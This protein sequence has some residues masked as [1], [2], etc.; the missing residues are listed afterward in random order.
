MS[1]FNRTLDKA[2]AEIGVAKTQGAQYSHA[3]L[4]QARFHLNLALDDA[5]RQAVT[6]YDPPAHP[7]ERPLYL[8]LGNQEEK[9]K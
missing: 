2:V 4:V 3:A 7:Y 9:Q 5:R 1:D 8:H 6:V